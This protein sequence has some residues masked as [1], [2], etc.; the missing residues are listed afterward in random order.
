MLLRGT[1]WGGAQADKT[2]DKKSAVGSFIY[3]YT[4][5]IE[6]LH[7]LRIVGSVSLAD[8][9]ILLEER[10][11][12]TLKNKLSCN[13]TNNKILEYSVVPFSLQ[14]L[15]KC[16]NTLI[17]S[18]NKPE[19]YV[20]VSNFLDSNIIIFK[21]LRSKCFRTQYRF[22]LLTYFTNEQRKYFEKDWCKRMKSNRNYFNHF[23]KSQ[24]Q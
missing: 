18:R 5:M 1:P 2:G 23:T 15:T 13:V 17:C 11:I 22:I 3:C 6:K 8:I 16:H 4:A 12:W 10:R 24:L 9:T 21:L 19:T 20:D 14:F 7:W